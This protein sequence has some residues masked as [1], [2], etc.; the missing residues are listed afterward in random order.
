MHFGKECINIAPESNNKM[1]ATIYFNNDP[2]VG[3]FSASYEMDLPVEKFEDDEHREDMRAAIKKLYTEL[4]G[5][6]YPSYVTF[7]DE[8]QD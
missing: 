8:K 1:K 3:I 4:D 6:F 2:S 5:E 7:S